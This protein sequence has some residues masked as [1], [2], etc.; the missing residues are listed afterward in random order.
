MQN[1]SVRNSGAAG[2]PAVLFDVTADEVCQRAGCQKPVPAAEPGKRGRRP[3]YCSTACK[4]KAARDKAK[5]DAARSALEGARA[6]LLR[7]AEAAVDVALA[8]LEAVDADPVAAYERFSTAHARLGV[9]VCEAARDVRDE[10]RWPGL[11][12]RALELRRAEEDLTRPDLLARV[13]PRLLAGEPTGPAFS[14]RSENPAPVAAPSSPPI[15]DRSE[16][17]PAPAGGTAPAVS[18]RSEKTL[19]SV[20]APAA[21]SAPTALAALPAADAAA[22]RA[23]DFETLRRAAC[24]DPVRRFGAPQR[25]DDL[26]LTFGP[27]WTLASWSGPEAVDVQLLHLGRPVGW[28][29]PLPDGPW[30]RAGHIA[31]QHRDDRTAT[32][33]TDPASG[34]RTYRSTGEALDALQ[35]AARTP[36]PAEAA[37]PAGVPDGVPRLALG[38]ALRS[39]PPTERGLGAPHRDY[40]GPALAR[41]TWPHRAPVQALEHGGH[42]VGWTEPYQD[43]NDWV[44]LLRGRQVVDAAD[45]E[46]LLSANPDDA[47]TLL[48][49]ALGQGL[50]APTAVRALPPVRG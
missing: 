33:L 13:D 4:S 9:R 26:A 41:L 18:D 44:T 38:P 39:K 11:S 29:A 35:R 12:G 40:A 21:P 42:L 31:A 1:G 43:T 5:A 28:S 36:F 8:F 30:G 7:G 37:L 50:A 19:T 15:S 2:T 46:P 10:I 32:I 17:A 47:L 49:L 23:Q 20:P 25:V 24:T 14:D 3:R 45:S 22:R 27:G 48:R 6:E 16:K 34:A